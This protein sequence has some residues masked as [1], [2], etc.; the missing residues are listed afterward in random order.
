[1]KTILQFLEFLKLSA[2]NPPRSQKGK[3]LILC[4][5][6]AQKMSPF[7]DIHVTSYFQLNGSTTCIRHRE[8]HMTY[9][10]ILPSS[11]HDFTSLQCC[12]IVELLLQSQLRHDSHV[13][14][15]CFY[16]FK[17]FVMHVFLTSKVLS[18]KFIFYLIVYFHQFAPN[19]RQ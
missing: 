5:C 8:K 4:P 2:I 13:L 18:K 9:F 1:M 14:L 12:T 15:I 3:L 16:L 10:N 19:S 11:R 17:T 7:Q 6:N